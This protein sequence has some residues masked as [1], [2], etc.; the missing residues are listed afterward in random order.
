MFPWKFCEC[1]GLNRPDLRLMMFC[2]WGYFCCLVFFWWVSVYTWDTK[3][4]RRGYTYVGVLILERRVKSLQYYWW[5]ENKSPFSGIF[6]LLL[7]P[8]SRFSGQSRNATTAA[9]LLSQTN[10]AVALADLHCSS[11]IPLVRVFSNFLKSS[12]WYVPTYCTL[13]DSFKCGERVRCLMLETC[14]ARAGRLPCPILPCLYLVAAAWE[15]NS[16]TRKRP[17]EF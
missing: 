7:I 15:Q 12:M 5:Q 9:C 17:A 13:C 3:R 11:I 8:R 4:K 16:S 6:S 2:L 1:L 14:A 10:A